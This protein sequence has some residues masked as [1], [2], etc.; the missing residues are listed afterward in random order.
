MATV[1]V[2][3]EDPSFCFFDCA[4]PYFEVLSSELVITGL[5]CG[6]PVSAIEDHSLIKPN[7][8]EDA[9]FGDAGFKVFELLS[10]DHGKHV[11]EGMG[12]VFEFD[13]AHCSCSGNGWLVLLTQ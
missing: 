4:K 10:F 13:R 11:G 2:G 1:K 9:G 12:L 5:G 8:F 3:F 7:R 6:V